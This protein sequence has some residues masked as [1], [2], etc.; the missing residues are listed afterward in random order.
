M[1]FDSVM[2]AAIARELQPLVGARVR[3]VWTGRGTSAAKETDEPRAVYLQLGSPANGGTLLID[4]HPQRARM[5][6]VAEPPPGGR[7]TPFTDALRRSLRGARLAGISQP[8]FD[9][10]LHLR[11]E[12]RDVIGNAVRAT[13]VAELMDR[14]SN[15][16][17]MDEQGI[18]IDA[19]KRLPPFLN[20]V[21]TV[22]PHRPYEAPPGDRRDPRDVADWDTELGT[23]EWRPALRRFHGISPLVLRAAEATIARGETPGE[24]MSKF[25]GSIATAET[26][27]R[28]WLCGQGQPY[29]V[30]IDAACVRCEGSLS[31]LLEQTAETVAEESQAVG[32]QATLR[33]HL[34]RLEARIEAQRADLARAREHATDAQF[35]Q[36]QGNLVLAHLREVGEAAAHDKHEVALSDGVTTHVI[37]IEP[38]WPPADNATR[39]FNR[40]RRA[41]KLAE[42]APAREEELEA[43]AARLAG[44]RGRL[45]AGPNASEMEDLARESRLE[46]ERKAPSRT[47]QQAQS[48]RPESKLR[49]ADIQG[50]TCFMGRNAIENQMLLSKVASA[51]D[52]WL[53]L[54]GRP[55]AHVIIKN[56]KGKV[57][58]DGVLEEAAR[59]LATT[60]LGQK[61]ANS[62]ER[63]EV[64][65]TAVKW[66]RAIKGAPGKVTLQRSQTRL[67]QL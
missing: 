7:P 57:V 5:H 36:E 10:V 66:V 48:A 33:S 9:R 41:R 62:G 64:L 29:P 3:E 28:A 53:H 61:G 59:W 60:A 31:E 65:Y 16:I 22:L 63:V 39:L 18:I 13:L 8:D 14:R 49:R 47:R 30:A 44:W 52:T 35:W 11:F 23:G 32:L 4:T 1:I 54:A 17:L 46:T 43:E 34:A 37:A 26:K 2:L 20:R 19:L 15:A 55:S 42:G 67:V 45:D 40:A 21:R 6:L 56:Q 12:N 24:A 27:K 38:K 58:P 25:F 51:S 50:W